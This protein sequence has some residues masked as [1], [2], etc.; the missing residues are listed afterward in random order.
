MGH[1]RESNYELQSEN[2]DWK[3]DES[4]LGKGKL[5]YR[6]GKGSEKGIIDPQR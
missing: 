3:E 6:Y 1:K 4:H 5:R 2:R